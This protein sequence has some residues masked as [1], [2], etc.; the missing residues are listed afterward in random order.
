MLF[1]APGIL[2]VYVW[3]C[4]GGIHMAV[5]LEEAVPLT[6]TRP[7]SSPELEQHAGRKL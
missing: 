1:L 2:L 5:F 6:V 4:H 7:S 3:G